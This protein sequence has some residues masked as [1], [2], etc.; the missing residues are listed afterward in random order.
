MKYVPSEIF[1]TPFSN[2]F[3]VDAPFLYCLKTSTNV[4][5]KAGILGEKKRIEQRRVKKIEIPLSKILLFGEILGWSLFL[6]I[7]FS[8]REKIF[9]TSGLVSRHSCMLRLLIVI[10]KTH[11]VITVFS[12]FPGVIS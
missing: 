2:P 7:A 1:N 9:S 10:Q 12:L 5:Y 4:N 6:N 3:L 11:L 8:I